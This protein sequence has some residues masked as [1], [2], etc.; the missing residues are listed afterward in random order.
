MALPFRS[1]L[2]AVTT[3]ALVP[4]PMVAPSGWPASM[5]APSSSPVMTRSSMHLPVG[6]RLERDVQAF[7]LEEAFLVGD[8]ERRHVGE[9]D[10]A[11]LELFF[12]QL[13][14]SAACVR[15]R[16]RAATSAQQATR[17]RTFA[18]AWHSGHSAMR[19]PARPKKNR[20]LLVHARFRMQWSRR[21]CPAGPLLGR[22]CC[23]RRCV[24]S[25]TRRATR[26]NASRVIRIAPSD[27]AGV[28]R[29]RAAATRNLIR[30]EQGEVSFARRSCSDHVPNQDGT[31]PRRRSARSSYRRTECSTFERRQR[32]PIHV[33]PIRT[34][35]D[36]TVATAA[37]TC[38][39][40]SICE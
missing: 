6:L 10:E 1:M 16:T 12:F 14:G 9:L 28:R 7:V 38:R 22:R 37:S 18:A 13:R 25:A 35:H 5:C 32:A 11:E 39:Q 30:N 17:R 23:T 27:L 3:S 36:A 26:S 4:K 21:R 2:N 33:G 31:R 8:G 40:R 20:R 24:A 29:S 19:F 15:A 34:S